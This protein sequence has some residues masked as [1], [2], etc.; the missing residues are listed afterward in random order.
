MFWRQRRNS[1]TPHCL[2][3]VPFVSRTRASRITMLGVLIATAALPPPRPATASCW[4]G[5]ARLRPGPPRWGGRHRF[6]RRRAGLL[7][8]A[9]PRHR[10]G[11]Q[12][13]RSAARQHGTSD[14]VDAAADAVLSPQAYSTAKTGDP[15][16]EMLRMRQPAGGLSDGRG[17]RH[18]LHPAPPVP[19]HR[20]PHHRTTAA[21]AADHHRAKHPRP[22]A[23][24]ASP[25]RP[26]QHRRAAHHR[27]RQPRSDARRSLLRRALLGQ[28]DRG[29]VRQNRR[30]RPNRG[31]DR[32]AGAALYRIALSGSRGD[33]RTR[34]F[35][36]RCTT[37]GL[38]GRKA[39]RCLRRHLK[40]YTAREIY[41]QLQQPD[42]ANAPSSA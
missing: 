30:R 4:A 34:T 32:R 16:V 8:A 25:R 9:A 5:G 41:Q 38:T 27:R 28:P 22:E 15:P 10:G 36:D 1:I 19:A 21:A 37:Q 17:H 11:G 14:T 12:P 20:E 35:L 29:I 39:I 18:C 6:P 24:A 40:R 26:G 3:W 2:L 33:H 42:L 7:P 13:A 31:D 23:V